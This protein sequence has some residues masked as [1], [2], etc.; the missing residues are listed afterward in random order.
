MGALEAL[1]RLVD[2]HRAVLAGE[3]AERSR[4]ELGEQRLS[5]RKG[6]RSPVELVE[7][8]TQVSGAEARRRIALGVAIRP[9]TALSGDPVSARFPVVAAA[10][11][12]GGLGADA[13]AVIVRELGRARP[14]ADPA[15]LAAAEEALG[16]RAR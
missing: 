12:D 16:D 2:A 4:P 11:A 3:V 1:G 10:L 5:A 15:A 7:R 14:A 13:A 6:C 8:V 9:G